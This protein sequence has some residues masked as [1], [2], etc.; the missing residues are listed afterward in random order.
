[1]RIGIVTTWFERGAAY[2]SRQYRDVL[3]KEH[4]V[5]IYARGVVTAKEN[6][7]YDS[8]GVTWGK[9]SGI[10]LAS[11]LD[12]RDFQQW[13]ENN[14]LDIVFF[15]EQSWWDPVLLCNK[16]GIKTGAYIDYYTKDTVPLFGIYDFLICNTRR[17]YSVFDWHPQAYYVPWG[18]DIQLFSPSDHNLAKAGV[19]T[20]FHSCGYSPERKGTDLLLQAFA[21]LTGPARLLIHSQGDLRKLIPELSSLVN[22]LVLAGRLEIMEETVAAPGLYYL[23]DVYVYPSRLDGIGLTVA[24]ALAC[25]L[26]VI[27]SD[28]GP[29]NEFVNENIGKLVDIV[30]YSSREDNYYWPQCEVDI[31]KLTRCMQEYINDID[32]IQSYKQRARSYA[33][34]NLDW[35]TNAHIIPSLFMDSECIQDQKKSHA[36]EKAILYEESRRTLG[37]RLYRAFPKLFKITYPLMRRMKKRDKLPG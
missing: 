21:N 22:E 26:P 34:D 37:I 4:D 9:M 20:F 28:N 36:K 15:N 30:R 32:S 14:A 19:V 1:V 16:L 25:G 11:A 29:M 35:D 12:V 2:V 18:T 5:Y 24:E 7:E 3:S 31:D 10:P 13:I 33:E 23:G 8:P 27:T 6:P 17:H